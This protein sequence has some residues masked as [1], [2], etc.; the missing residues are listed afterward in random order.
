VVLLDHVWLGD[1]AIGGVAVTTCEDCAS[2]E[3][4]GLL[5][6]NVAGGYNVTIDADRREVIFSARQNFNRRLDVRPF[7]D[8]EASFMRYPG[9]RVELSLDFENHTSR[10][11]LGASA[12]ISCDESEWIVDIGEVEP[13][14]LT[15]V[16][17]RLPRHERCESY[18]VSLDAAWW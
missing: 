5:G 12:K 3:N 4:A 10:D 14:G 18:Q 8:L 13:M 9:G 15:E 6:L 17:R 1:L 16:A 11:I 2:E 7:S